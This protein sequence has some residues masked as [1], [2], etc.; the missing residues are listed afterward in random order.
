MSQHWTFRNTYSI[1]KTHEVLSCVNLPRK[2]ASGW[3]CANGSFSSERQSF[4]LSPE[5]A[6]T[7][8][9]M[10]KW[11]IANPNPL[12]LRLKM[13]I[14]KCTIIIFTNWEIAPTGFAA[15]SSLP[16]CLG[17]YLYPGEVNGWPSIYQMY[18]TRPSTNFQS[19][20]QTSHDCRLISTSRAAHCVNLL[21]GQMLTFTIQ[22]YDEHSFFISLFIL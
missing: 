11:Q 1:N 9:K 6:H 17:I 5:T 22:F 18:S 3:S 4:S 7:L 12:E 19:L 13:K 20:K 16:Q 2:H 15:Q 14:Q 21:Y 8:T 10:V